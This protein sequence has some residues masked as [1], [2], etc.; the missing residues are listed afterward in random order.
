[1]PGEIESTM[2]KKRMVDGIF[3]EEETWGQILASAKQYGA[4]V[5]E[6]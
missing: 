6:E 5:G 3:V 1:M 2:K 4:E